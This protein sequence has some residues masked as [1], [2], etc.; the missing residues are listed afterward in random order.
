VPLEEWSHSLEKAGGLLLVDPVA[1]RNRH[2]LAHRQHF[3]GLGHLTVIGV[4]R[5]KQNWG[6]N[7]S[8]ILSPL[9]LRI[10]QLDKELTTT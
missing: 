2:N 4:T 1:D 9:R 10:V 3:T 8:R 5:D 6:L 7:R